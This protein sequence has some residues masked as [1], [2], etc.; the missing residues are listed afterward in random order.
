MR[1]ERPKGSRKKSLG[2]TAVQVLQC[3]PSGKSP[4]RQKGAGAGR[5]GNPDEP[6]GHRISGLSENQRS[7]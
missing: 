5:D 7:Q 2:T 3:T 1:H 4:I 6:R